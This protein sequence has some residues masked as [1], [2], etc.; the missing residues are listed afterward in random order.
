MFPKLERKKVFRDPL[1]GYIYVTE[2][3]ISDLIDTKEFQRL[4]RIR[5]LSGVSMVFHGAEHSRFSHSLGVYSL[6]LNVLQEVDI[7]KERLSEYEQIVFLAAA[8]L[9]D[10][11]HGPYSHA[12]EHVFKVRHEKST[13]NIIEGKTEINTVLNQYHKDLAADIASVILK[14]GKFTIIE[15]LISSQLDVDRMDYLERDAFHTG[16]AYGRLDKDRIIRMLTLHNDQVVFKEGAVHAIENYLMSRYH[17]Y[18]QVYYHPA[19]RSY[20]VMLESIYKRILD[21][22]KSGNL[23]DEYAVYLKTIIENGFEEEAYFE[24]DD[25]YVNGLIKRFSHCEDEIL[26]GLCNEFLTRKL[27]KYVSVNMNQEQIIKDIIDGR[28]LTPYEYKIDYISQATY[29][30]D[31]FDIAVSKILILSK[32]G[33]LKTLDQISPI[34]RGL[35]T[36]GIK[37]DQKLYYRDISHE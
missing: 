3:V 26:S 21:L 22:I 8:L 12:F 19:A 28:H 23:N 6:A 5:Q 4:R 37:T 27:F 18:W 11:G 36:S 32:E 20:E 17:M 34:I 31:E 14:T 29:L 7:L 33:E 2:A 16:A 10:V 15:Q 35:S 13:A 9:H 1:Y 30:V 25:Y 24:L